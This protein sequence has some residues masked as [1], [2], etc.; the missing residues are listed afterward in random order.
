MLERSRLHRDRR[1]VDAV[2]ED[3]IA[4]ASLHPIHHRYVEYVRRAPDDGITQHEEPLGG[5]G[6]L[7]DQVD[8]VLDH[9]RAEETTEDLTGDGAVH[10]RVVP[11]RPAAMIGRDLV[12]VGAAPAVGDGH[13]DVVRRSRWRDVQPVG[14]EVRHLAQP[15]LERDRDH[16]PGAHAKRGARSGSVVDVCEACPGPERNL[17]G[18]CDESNVEPPV[19]ARMHRRLRQA[20]REGGRADPLECQE[21]RCGARHR[22]CAPCDQEELAPRRSHRDAHGTSTGRGG[23][24]TK[25]PFAAP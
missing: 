1:P 20:C 17:R 5:R 12:G 14:V 8:R 3:A 16:V 25:V 13:E 4:F 18:S 15:V 7:R 10:V 11:E 2:H 6:E 9:D 22:C 23:T 24:G 19:L 21:E